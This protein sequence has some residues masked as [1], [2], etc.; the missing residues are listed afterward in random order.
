MPCIGTDSS[1]FRSRTSWVTLGHLMVLFDLQLLTWSQDKYH[2]QEKP[3]TM[4]FNN[5]AMLP[6]AKMGELFPPL[7]RPECVLH[8]RTFCIALTRKTFLKRSDYPIQIHSQSVNVLKNHE[9]EGRESGA[10]HFPKLCVYS[11]N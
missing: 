10:R 4:L 3:L 11:S 2:S 5:Q 6:M 7:H 8:H 9:R 1:S